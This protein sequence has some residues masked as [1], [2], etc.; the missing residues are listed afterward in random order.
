MN[1]HS[2]EEAMSLASA[3]APSFEHP[4]EGDRREQIIAAAQRAFVRHGF[5]AATMQ[6]VA[7]EA[8]MSAGNLYRY[9]RSKE[10][11]VDGI[12]AVDQRERSA[13]FAILLGS[14]NV[15]AT[16]AEMLRTHLLAKPRERAIMYIEIT[17]EAARNPRIAATTLAIDEEVRRGLAELVEI[18]KAKGEAAAS[19]D[20]AFAA[21]V[22]FTLVGGLF[23]RRALE[24]D[25]DADVE[26]AMTL[27]VLK[28]LFA[29]VIAPSQNLAEAS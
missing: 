22:I 21:R 17:A 13:A 20:A 10:A 12:C 24:P 6:Q 3:A 23:K 11:I 18:A 16:L 29:G 2:H 8:G 7:E 9:F 14:Q 28:A 27:G 25:F 15:L 4:P 19:L 1:V 5:H 26:A